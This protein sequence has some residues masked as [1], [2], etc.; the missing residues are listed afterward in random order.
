[1]AD[2][3]RLLAHER[4]PIKLI[5]PNQG[6]E[7][8]IKSGGTPPKPFRTVDAKYR[9]HLSNQVAALRNAVIPQIHHIGAAPVRVKLLTQAVAKSHRPEH[10]FS[11]DSCP[12]V[13]A[14][15]LGELF[16][17]ATAK[18]LDRLTSTIQNNKS[19]AITKELSCV[20]SIE[21]ITPNYRR[22]GIE[23]VDVLR[24][25]PRGKSGFVTR[26]RLFNFGGARE[27]GSLVEDFEIVPTIRSKPFPTSS[28]PRWSCRENP[29][30]TDARYCAV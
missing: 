1:M 12:I 30:E 15:K 13:G 26:V 6:K 8:R 5:M 29:S 3:K 16:V 27:Q 19:D 9:T 14:G 4:L 22:G 2:E 20:E 28:R 25:S 21:P 18:G 23:T 11:V 10:L 7:S 17:K 24:R